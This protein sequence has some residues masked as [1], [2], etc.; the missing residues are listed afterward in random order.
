MTASSNFGNVLSVLVASAF[1]QSHAAAPL[2]AMTLAIV[3]IGLW[4]PLGPLAGYFR[5][6]AL[7][8]AF[9]GWL[10]AIL[11]GYCTLTTVMKRIYIR[12]YGWQ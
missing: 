9:Y 8:V 6:Q 3:A 12:R 10:V 4:L 5:L 2:M 1:V 11:V 7:P